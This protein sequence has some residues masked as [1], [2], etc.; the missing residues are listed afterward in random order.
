VTA[1]QDQIPDNFCF[2]CGAANPDGLHLK[3]EWDGD[4]AV[5]R[6]MPAERYSA[7]PK[8]VL[9]GGIIATLLDCHGVCTAIAEDY[10]REGRAIGSEPQLWHATTTL[11]VRYLRPAPTDAPLTL[12][13]TVVSAGDDG[14]VV[15]CRLEANGKVRAEAT[16]TSVRVP[17]SW[18]HGA[19][20]A[21]PS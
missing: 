12:N 8:H 10:R 3:S 4:D 1:F 6:W 11:D 16:V 2:G 18:R 9:N 7:G 20:S 15:E 19:P 13:A 17:D 5:A 14:T 21:P